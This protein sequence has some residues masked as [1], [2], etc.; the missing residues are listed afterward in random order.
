LC[1]DNSANVLPEREIEIDLQALNKKIPRES[2]LATSD[3]VLV[4]TRQP[5]RISVFKTGRLLIGN[6]HTEQAAKQV[7]NEVWKQIRQHSRHGNLDFQQA[8]T[9]PTSPDP[10]CRGQARPG[11]ASPPKADR[12]RRRAADTSRSNP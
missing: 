8:Y 9:V 3:S 4:Y 12:L 1:G 7:A 6:V 5:H 2:I 10:N 11:L